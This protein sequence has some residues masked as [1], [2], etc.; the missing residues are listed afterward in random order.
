MLH[1]YKKAVTSNCINIKKNR[2]NN[3]KFFNA[4]TRF[5]YL[6]IC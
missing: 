6:F 4:D 5:Y 3:E 1:F 2:D